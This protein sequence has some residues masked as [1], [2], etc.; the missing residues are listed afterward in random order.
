MCGIVGIITAQDEAVSP[1]LLTQMVRVI[2]HRGPD[3][4]GIYCAGSVGLG[5][6]RLSILDLT[7]AGHQPMTNDD[8]SLWLVYNGEIYNFQELRRNLEQKGHHFHSRTD[9]EVILHAYE[10]YGEACLE[11][12]NGIFAFALWD[13]KN[14]RLFCAR[15]RLGVKPFYYYSGERRFVFASEIKAILEDTLVPRR[16]NMAGLNNYFTFGRATSPTTIYEGIR[17]LLP[18]HYLLLENGKLSI[19]R[20][21]DL[22]SVDPDAVAQERNVADEVRQFIHDSVGMQMVSDVPVGVFLSGGLDSSAVLAFASEFSNQPMKTFAVGFEDSQFSELADA[23]LVAQTFGADHH[24]LIISPRDVPP[25]LEK[26]AWHYDEPFGDTAAIPVYLLSQ[27]ARQSV[28]VALTGEGGDE[29]FG[30][31]RR[32][33]AEQYSKLFQLLPVAAQKLLQRSVG[34]LPR[35]RRLKKLLQAMSVAD[36]ADRYEEWL[37]VYDKDAKNQLFRR[38]VCES[39]P[40]TNRN[41]EMRASYEKFPALVNRLLY[42]DVKNLLPDGY[43]EKMD[44]ATMAFGLEA[45][46]PLLDHRLVELAFR[47]PPSLKVN[48]RKTKI[49]LRQAMANVLPPRILNKPKYG[50]T[51]PTD[52]WFRTSLKSYLTEILKDPIMDRIG[53]FNAA[54]ISKLLDLH[55]SGTE[56]VDTRIYLL[57]AFVNWYKVYMEPVSR[58]AQQERVPLIPKGVAR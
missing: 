30:G 10:E 28:T 54:Y 49:V 9:T 16:I 56:I 35:L 27:Y 23:R 51:A 2:E 53:L 19:H 25:I 15:D 42:T 7:D 34:F 13:V 39:L 41:P 43:L 1:E 38:E 32:Y 58:P 4:Q 17:K 37:S 24:E 48:L 47:V 29:L 26:L 8:R 31:Y 57:V 5:N 40:G 33:V 45:R 50:F 44:K 46:V 52:Y 11:L 22:E 3:D 55:L 12:F 21:W 20:Y 14:R 6:V 36:P 18:G